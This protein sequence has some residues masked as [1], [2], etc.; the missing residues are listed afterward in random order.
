MGRFVEGLG[1]CKGRRSAL[2]E[3]EAAPRKATFFEGEPR[4]RHRHPLRFHPSID[5]LQGPPRDDLVTFFESTLRFRRHK[6]SRWHTPCNLRVGDDSKACQ[7]E[8]LVFPPWTPEK[9][10]LPID[11]RVDFAKNPNQGYCNAVV[12]PKMGKAR[13]AFTKYLK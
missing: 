2:K 9:P 1:G 13:S 4:T 10:E 11:S 8:W 12:A 6:P 3:Y 7:K 5:P